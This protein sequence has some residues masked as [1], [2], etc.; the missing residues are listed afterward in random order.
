VTKSRTQQ[1]A[2]WM[3]VFGSAERVAWIG[4]QPCVSCHRDGSDDHPNHN[5]HTRSGGM[6]RKADACWIVPLCFGC[7]KQEHD[8]R[9]ARLDLPLLAL[10]IERRWQEH[11]SRETP[12]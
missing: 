11:L 10:S 4:R 3:R 5:H 2:N 1:N 12:E 6:G 7:H 9:L 8:N